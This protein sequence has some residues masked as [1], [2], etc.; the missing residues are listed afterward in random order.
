M[1]A[2][3]D[4]GRERERM[5]D[6]QIARRDVRDPYVLD[7][8][9]RVPREQYL[10]QAD[11]A[12]LAYADTALPIERGPDDFA[13]LHCRFD[14]RGGRGQARGSRTRGRRGIRVCGRGAQPDRRSGLRHRAPCGTRESRQRFAR[15]GYVNIEVRVGDGTLGWA[16]APPFDGILVSAG[17]PKFRRS[18]RKSSLRWA[19]AS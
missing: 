6:V 15:L 3:L 10:S 1:V 18:L 5:V 12:E 2:T 19:V 4:Y 11:L 9:R 8:M 14:D 7:A 17:G 13:A 16:D